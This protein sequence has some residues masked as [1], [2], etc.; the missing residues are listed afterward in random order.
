MKAEK[1]IPITNRNQSL[2]IVIAAF[3]V[4][5]SSL[6]SLVL[7][8]AILSNIIF[9]SV[10]AQTENAGSSFA[11]FTDP[12]GLTAEAPS[13]WKESRNGDAI[14]LSCPGCSSS[15][16]IY[17]WSP[18]PGSFFPSSDTTP[19]QVFNNLLRSNQQQI[20][21][22][23]YI[24]AKMSNDGVSMPAAVT[25]YKIADPQG[26]SQ[27]NVIG[28][29]AYVLARGHL[30]EYEF[31]AA[32]QD[33]SAFKPIMKH[34]IATLHYPDNT[35]DSNTIQGDNSPS[36]KTNI[37]LSCKMFEAQQFR[38]LLSS[39]MGGGPTLGIGMNP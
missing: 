7:S 35:G 14:V 5:L 27:S 15:I 31:A 3:A 10:Y 28:L 33:W 2:P 36:G 23:Q 25:I 11:V 34:F 12:S 29:G 22:I 37:C 18:S 17:A 24:D 9:P 13:D 26:G 32:P 8:T 6:V 16:I 4:S 39:M 38:S 20:P 1:F 19:E 30:Y 21:G